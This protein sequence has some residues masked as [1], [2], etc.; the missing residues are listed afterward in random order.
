M[1]MAESE[2]QQ[3]S[4]SMTDV[5]TRMNHLDYMR[6]LWANA[7]ETLELRQPYMLSDRDKSLIVKLHGALE[8]LDD[9]IAKDYTPWK[10]AR[11]ING[12]PPAERIDGGRGTPLRKPK[13]KQ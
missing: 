8:L 10:M 2:Y 4:E 7:L 6:R 11:E 12:L 13:G 3:P 1:S 9:H 5:G